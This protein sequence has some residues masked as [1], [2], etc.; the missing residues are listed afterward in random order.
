MLKRILVPASYVAMA[1]LVLVTG[2][3]VTRGAQGAQDAEEEAIRIT[4]PHPFAR[5]WQAPKIDGRLDDACWND[6]A[7][8][9]I[10]YVFDG[11]TAPG[12]PETTARIMWDDTFLYIGYE[13]VD[14]DIWSFSDKHDD[15]MWLGDVV[16]FFIKPHNDAKLYFEFNFAPNATF[17]DARMVSRGG[18]GFPRG[19]TWESGA[20][21]ASHLRGTDNNDQDDDEGYSVEVAIPLAALELT[22]ET[23]ET[24]T[25]AAF[26]Y[27]YGKQYDNQLLLMSIP[28]APTLGFH[29][30]EYYQ[31]FVFARKWEKK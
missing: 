22:P 29:S 6:A 18:G 27:D 30:F 15:T 20:K 8:L 31:P 9:E 1:A 19:K 13:A 21:V 14:R 26:R 16:E 23:G 11:D 25:F 2:A 10:G 12:I 3:C 4:K 7:V 28:S 5:A 17:M 24:G